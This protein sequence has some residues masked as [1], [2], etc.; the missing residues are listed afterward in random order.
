MIVREILWRTG[1]VFWGVVDSRGCSYC[2]W[3][4]T[5]NLY[6]FWTFKEDRV[7]PAALLSLVYILKSSAV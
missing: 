5:G 7:Y 2:V 4:S 6:D 3:S 1:A